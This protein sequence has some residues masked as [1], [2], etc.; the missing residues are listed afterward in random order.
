MRTIDLNCDLGEGAS[1]DEALM[2]LITSAN[3]ACGL[4]AGDAH[5]MTR[6]LRWARQHGVAV[7]AHPGYADREHFG[8]RELNLSVPEIESLVLFQIGALAVLAR[9]EGVTL[10]HVKPHGALYNQAAR[11]RALATAIA[12]AVRGFSRE[13]ILVGLAGS[14]LIEAGTEA[15]LRVA[16]E[17]FPDRGYN[18]D[19]TLMSRALPGAVHENAEAV[20]AN[21]VRLATEGIMLGAR[22]VSVDT[23][24]IHGDG[25][26]AVEF[27]QAVRA[28][29]EQRGC[30]LQ[31]L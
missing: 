13:V 31:P 21:A 11:D 24:C 2:P 28:A 14:A 16:S 6:T 9:A 25:P 23:L 17:G 4:H 19:G 12:R 5:T 27:A 29:L 20:A 22:R 18:P 8:R 30:G 10:S 1:N 3:V 26:H 7:G 15:G